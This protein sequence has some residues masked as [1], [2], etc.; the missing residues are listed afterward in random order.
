MHYI[1]CY[2]SQARRGLII[3]N[4]TNSI[5]ALK[6]HVNVNHSIIFLKFEGKTSSLRE[7]EWQLTK[8]RPNV[9]NILYPIFLLQK[10]PSRKMIYSKNI[11]LK[12]WDF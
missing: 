12:I 5:T 3:Y 7:K 10:N 4:T 1:F 6:K 9:V 2:N 8:T 11:F